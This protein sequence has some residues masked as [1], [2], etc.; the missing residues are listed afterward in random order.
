MSRTMSAIE[1]VLPTRSIPSR[2]RWN[3]SIWR[4]Y[5][6]RRML[7]S[8]GASM[9]VRIVIVPPN[10]VLMRPMTART[11]SSSRKKLMT[12]VSRCRRG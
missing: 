12:L 3:S 11:G 8:S 9:I 5:S 10:W 2:K 4:R 7:P 6:G 1:R